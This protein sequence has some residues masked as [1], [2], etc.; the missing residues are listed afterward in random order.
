MVQSEKRVCG[1]VVEN[2]A[3]KKLTIDEVARLC[4]V[5]KTTIS[6]YLNGKYENISADTRERIRE[7]IRQHGYRP[8]K[9]AQRLKANRTMLIGCVFGDIASPFS[10]LLFSG[11][12]RACDEAGYQILFADSGEDPARERRAI[13]GFLETRVDGLIINTS[14]GNDEYL[15]EL[16][17]R[18]VNIVLADRGLETPGVI[19]TV[20]SSNSETAYECVR[21]LFGCGYTRVAFFSEGVHS[22]TPRIL[23]RQG[24]EH[25]VCECSGTEPV[26]YEFERGNTA[27]CVRCINDFRDR[28]PGERIAI[29]AVNGVAAQRVL[30]AMNEIGISPGYEYGLCSFDDWSWLQVFPG[31]VTSVRQQ[32]EMIGSEAVRLLIERITGARDDNA[33]AADIK[34]ATRIIV[35][36]STKDKP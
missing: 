10:A 21:Y 7:V 28:C 19:D 14:G 16:H 1:E 12:I 8:N 18:G 4:G 32:T 30:R 13:E 15:T 25:A 22:V 26:S 34:L 5:S 6:R 29:L 20:S 24:Y 31:G 23:R 3:E 9:T 2:Q 35:R 11:M 33:P 27:D 36:G 17:D